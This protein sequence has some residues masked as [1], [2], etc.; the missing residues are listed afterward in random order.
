MRRLTDSLVRGDIAVWASDTLDVGSTG[1]CGESNSSNSELEDH[2][3]EH[4]ETL[5]S[6]RDSKSEETL[7]ATMPLLYVQR[8]KL[9]LLFSTS[10]VG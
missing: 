3:V 8:A 7:S 5:E 6:S 2:C 10:L 4:S 9:L 1:V